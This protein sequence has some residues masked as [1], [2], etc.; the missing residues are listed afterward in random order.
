L[1]NVITL[2]GARQVFLTLKE[3]FEFF[4]NFPVFLAVS[5]CEDCEKIEHKKKI[6]IIVRVQTLN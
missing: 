1:T 3:K 2:G 4:R 5:K 6:I